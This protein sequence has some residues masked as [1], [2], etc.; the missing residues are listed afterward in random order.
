MS[1]R[2]YIAVATFLIASRAFAQDAVEVE[3]SLVAEV[4]ETVQTPPDRKAYRF[5]PATVLTQDEVVYYTVRIRNPTPV[6]ARDVI[7]VQRVP[8]NTAYLADSASGPG[9]D[10]TYSTDGGHTFA[11]ADALMMKDDAGATRLA[12]PQ[13][14]THIRWHLRNVLAPSAVALA[15]FRAVFK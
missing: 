12:R 14:Y 2:T 15:R 6:A 9:A 1:R 4:R 13:D 7:V 5:V 10:I 8:A 11:A 3:T